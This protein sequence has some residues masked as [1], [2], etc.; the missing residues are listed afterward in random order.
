MTFELPQFRVIGQFCNDSGNYITSGLT[1]RHI[2]SGEQRT[3]WH[4]QYNDWPNQ[5]CPDDV[6]GYLG[7]MSVSF[8]NS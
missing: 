4:L 3:V 5:G 7:K 8:A 2:P 1:V 6:Q